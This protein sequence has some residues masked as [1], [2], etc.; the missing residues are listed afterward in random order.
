[1]SRILIVD[2]NAQN[3]YIARFL[4]E[5]AGFEVAEAYS[6]MACLDLCEH[7]AFD[8]ILMDIQMPGMD[9]LQTMQALRDRGVNTPVVALTAKAMA[10]DREAI[11]SAGAQGYI[12]KPFE[13]AEFAAQVAGYIKAIEA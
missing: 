10:G 13:P 3:L 8:L 12:A 11:L 1:M 6:G 2:D 5:H 9:G 4:L 7:Q